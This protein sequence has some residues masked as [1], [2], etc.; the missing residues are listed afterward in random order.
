MEVSH[1]TNAM[2]TYTADLNNAN[3]RDLNY[4]LPGS[5]DRVSAVRYY[6]LS[7]TGASNLNSVAF[8]IFY[9]A[10]DGVDDPSNLRMVMDDGSSNWT[11]I[12]GTGSG[13]TS[14]SIT[15]SPSGT[16]NGIIVLGNTTGGSNSL[17]VTWM[18]FRAGN[19]EGFSLLEWATAAEKNADFFEVQRSFDGRNFENL[20]RIAAAGNSATPKYYTYIDRTSPYTI[21][22]YR[23]RQ[24][25]LDGEYTF[26][27]MKVLNGKTSPTLLFPNPPVQQAYTIYLSSEF[28]GEI[29]V[30]TMDLNGTILDSRTIDKPETILQCSVPPSNSA[31]NLLVQITD[32]SGKKWTGKLLTVVNNE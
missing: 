13:A 10:G 26:S 25:D 24:V 15:S 30:N 9:D 8:T 3:A 11:D 16:M 27:S 2:V 4:G 29:T 32:A 14:G 19:T 5:I 7:R 21:V 6:S 31:K 17:P 18:Y 22:Y 12:G 28:T 23:I 1:A 20:T